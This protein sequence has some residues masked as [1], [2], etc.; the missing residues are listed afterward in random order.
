MKTHHDKVRIAELRKR[1]RKLV[2]FKPNRNG[3]VEKVVRD[4]VLEVQLDQDGTVRVMYDGRAIY[5]I[6]E[7]DY[8]PFIVVEYLDDAIHRLRQLLV[9]EDLA[10]I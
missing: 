1:S 2:G 10:G 3:H 9:L 8:E 5:F 6:R 7:D 4:G